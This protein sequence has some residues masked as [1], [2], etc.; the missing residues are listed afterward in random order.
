MG[1][2]KIKF[3]PL[4]ALY[5]FLC[6]YFSWFN[7]IFF[8]V[9]VVTL[10]EFGHY[11]AAKHYGYQMESIIFSLSG[12]GITTHNKF[13]EKH[14]IVISICGPLIN[15]ILIT[16][17]ICLWWI[18]PLSYLY[19]Y[20]FLITNLV[21]MLFNLVPIYPLDGGRIIIDVLSLRGKDMGK[22]LKINKYFCLVISIVFAI[23]FIV[24]I[25]FKTNYNL[26]ITSMFL[27]INSITSDKNKYYDKIKSLNKKSDKPLEV[28]IFKVQTDNE[29][30]LLKYLSPRYYSIFKNIKNGKSN[31]ITEDDLLR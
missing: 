9:V 27:A 25:F 18:F 28:K 29:K 3:H 7:K 19:T 14:D 23:L 21:V 24:S 8:Y 10:H 22:C 11:F 13:A 12:A 15:L 4:F 5:V 17:T 30:E 1:K 31:T 16:I 26:L 2:L 20:D 6:I